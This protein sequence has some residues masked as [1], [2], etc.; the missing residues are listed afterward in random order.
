VDSATERFIVTAGGCELRA[1]LLDLARSRDGRHP[2]VHVLGDHH[3]GAD[4]RVVTDAHV[5]DD[6]GACTDV[7]PIPDPGARTGVHDSRA[8]PD[9]NTLEDHAVVTHEHVGSDVDA[10]LMADVEASA[11]LRSRIDLDAEP[12]PHEAGEP[13]RQPTE[14]PQRA[15]SPVLCPVSESVGG[16]GLEAWPR[17][18]APVEF[19]ILAQGGEEAVLRG[20]PSPSRSCL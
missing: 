7:D 14:H 9:P 1:P 16:E 5:T 19:E 18:L 20:P 15:G 8:A 17:Q 10:A 13:G 4:P 12:T 2:W 11:E 3:V 6:D